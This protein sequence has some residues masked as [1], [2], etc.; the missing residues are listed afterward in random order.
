[1]ARD[2][3]TGALIHR[4]K[5]CGAGETFRLPFALCE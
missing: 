2:G 4:K 3:W 5:S 1:V